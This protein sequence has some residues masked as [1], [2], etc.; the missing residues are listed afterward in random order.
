MAV[1]DTVGALGD[2]RFIGRVFEDATQHKA[3]KLPTIV[4]NGIHALAVDEHRRLFEPT[5]WPG[6][7]AVGQ[8]MEQR[9]F[10][11]SHANVGGGY[12]RDGLFLRP[13]QWIH[14]HAAAHGLDFSVRIRTLSPIFE[15]SF[16]RDPLGEIGYGSYYFT[17]RFKR[18]D[19]AITLGGR[20]RETI[21]YTV[22][23]KWAWNKSYRPYALSSLLGDTP[24]RRA[25]ARQ[26]DD[27]QILSVLP[28]TQP[29]IQVPDRGFSLQ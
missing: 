7:T 26:L 24:R 25:P 3:L 19:R 5:L 16:P 28:A 21:D 20:T 27:V 4:Q 17:Q 11:G 12:D 18:F 22:L 8:T 15:T 23:E 6:L 9:W 1:W 2:P 10:V 13:L 29:W 14:D